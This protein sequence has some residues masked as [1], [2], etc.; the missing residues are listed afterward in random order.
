MTEPWRPHNCALCNAPLGK[1]A[2]EALCS[3]CID[4]FYEKGQT[5]VPLLS[6]DCRRDIRAMVGE[7]IKVAQR[8]AHEREEEGPTDLITIAA[9]EMPCRAHPNDTVKVELTD[10]K[11]GRSHVLVECTASNWPMFMVTWGF[12]I[13][14]RLEEQRQAAI[15]AAAQS[16]NPNLAAVGAAALQGQRQNAVRLIG[17][18]VGQ[19]LATRAMQL[20]GGSVAPSGIDYNDVPTD[21]DQ[22]VEPDDPAA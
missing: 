6:E 14:T 18:V 16:P 2:P 21:P 15:V 4:V 12:H 10:A 13:R 8:L 7:A 11:T 3:D 20:L 19:M 22:D 17:S 5:A 1:K 9:T